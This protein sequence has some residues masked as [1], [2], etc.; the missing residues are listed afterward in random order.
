MI[1]KYRHELKY[2]LPYTDYVVLQKRLAATMPRD[3]NAGEEGKYFI[4]S[5]YFDD[6]F[7]SSFSEKSAG[8]DDRDKFR[9]RYYNREP[10]KF[11]LERKRKLSGYIH[12]DSISLSRQE[13]ENIMQGKYAF[14]MERK[15][16][17]AHVMYIEFVTRY[18]KPVVIVDYEREP[19]VFPYEDVRVTFDTDIRT[20]Y[21]ATDLFDTQLST[22][23]VIDNNQPVLEIKF[24]K[25]MPREIH[26]LLQSASPQRSQISKYC[27]CRK[28]EL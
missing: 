10:N 26:R 12:K 21:R 20:A 5:L 9:I 8:V 23:P 7:D 15:E 6:P 16:A 1:A 22:Y 24:N 3:P 27:L 25:A 28:F 4:R 14:L 2:Y 19:F 17:F 13:C 11:K 18:L